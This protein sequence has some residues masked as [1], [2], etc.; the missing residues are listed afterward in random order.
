MSTCISCPL[1]RVRCRADV[2]TPLHTLIARHRFAL[3][4]FLFLFPFAVMNVIVA[5][6]PEPVYSILGSIGF[7]AAAPWPVVILVA[8]IL[9]GAVI[10]A[11]PQLRERKIYVL[12]AIFSVVLLAIFL[13]LG[14]ALGEEIYRCDILG[15]PN[16]D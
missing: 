6:R 1:S 12:N 14:F 7:I 13:I 2:F 11:W 5:L 8:L 9:V 10:A 15:V 16:C 3:I 4:G